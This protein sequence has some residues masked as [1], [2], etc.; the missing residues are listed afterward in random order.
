MQRARFDLSCGIGALATAM[1]AASMPA[2]ASEPGPREPAPP[3]RTV[4]AEPPPMTPAPA[5]EMVPMPPPAALEAPMAPQQALGDMPTPCRVPADGGAAGGLS[6][7]AAASVMDCVMAHT[8]YGDSGHIFA[9]DYM[10]W[11][12]RD[13]APLQSPPHND[14]YVAVYANER[15]TTQSPFLS[16]GK[17]QQGAVIATPTFS[18]ANDGAV[19]AGPLVLL[20]KMQRGFLT[21]AGNWRYTVIAPDGQIVAV[22]KSLNHDSLPFCK[23]CDDTAGTAIFNALLSGEA[24]PAPTGMPGGPAMPSGP[25]GDV[26]DPSQL[27][28]PAP[29]AAPR[30]NVKMIDPAQTME[31]KPAAPA[32]APAVLDPAQMMQPSPAPRPAPAPAKPQPR[33]ARPASDPVLDPALMMQQEPA[34]QDDNALPAVLDPTLSAPPAR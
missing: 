20:E 3:M 21:Y 27:I 26:L 24:P 5:P 13:A 34:R 32:P 17:P 9:R 6:A 4:P 22:S 8:R 7:A 12:R 2:M 15:A 30:G 1:L 14:R 25:A 28:G 10:E 23:T 18:V 29:T 33:P 31:P 16:A 19:S 11:A